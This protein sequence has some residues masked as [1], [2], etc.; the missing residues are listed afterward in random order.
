MGP[1]I[2]VGQSIHQVLKTR[3]H[4]VSKFH[5]HTI[6]IAHYAI[7]DILLLPSIKL[8]YSI[9]LTLGISLGDLSPISLSSPISLLSSLLFSP[10]PVNDLLGEPKIPSPPINS[11]YFILIFII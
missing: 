2:D 8:P 10:S 11:E 6:N 1:S 4:C 5:F 3:F 9:T 7:I